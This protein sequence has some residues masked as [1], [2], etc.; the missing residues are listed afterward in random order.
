MGESGD[1]CEKM[2]EGKEKKALVGEVVMYVR[3][4]FREL[5]GVVR[6]F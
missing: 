1:F 2:K 4:C 3:T 5:R 6:D